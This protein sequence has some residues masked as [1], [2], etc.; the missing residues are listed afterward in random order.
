MSLATFVHP[1]IGS[2]AVG[3]TVRLDGDEGHHAGDRAAYRRRVHHLRVPSPA[4]PDGRAAA[5]IS[6][7]SRRGSAPCR[8]PLR[9]GLTGR[10]VKMGG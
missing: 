5:T 10:A 8:D 9:H 2:A 4:R 7:R 6:A 3:E 1:A